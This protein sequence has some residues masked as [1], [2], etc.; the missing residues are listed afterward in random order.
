MKTW[1]SNKIKDFRNF[2]NQSLQTIYGLD[3]CDAIFKTLCLYYL[4]KTNKDLILQPDL[5]LSESEILKFQF[6]LK[7]LLKNEP[8]QYI[9]GETSFFGL[10]FFVDSHV[11]IP[12]PETEELVQW[13]LD[14]YSF[15]K[16]LNIVDACTGSGCIAV[17]LA[18]FLTKTEVFAID[19]DE[20]ALAVAKKNA[21]FHQLKIH[22]LHQNLLQASDLPKADILVS[23]PPY[24]SENEKTTMRRNVLDF[25]P[26]LALFPANN[27][28]LIFYKHFVK[29]AI[30]GKF[31]LAYFEINQYK[32]EALEHWLKGFNFKSIEFKRDLS[33][34]WRMLKIEF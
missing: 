14:D 19:V 28:D 29:L 13:V 2:F 3:E 33:N 1:K 15:K 5:R 6:A 24:V 32:K 11:L 34:H 26:H 16:E 8:L 12:R 18:K 10:R 31:K 9:M 17:S 27:D 4:N 22:F 21:D 30:K 23:N 20:D 25:E 7:R